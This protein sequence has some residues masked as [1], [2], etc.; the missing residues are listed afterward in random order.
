[1]QPLTL[2]TPSPPPPPPPAPPLGLMRQ[3]I[4]VQSVQTWLPHAQLSRQHAHI[5]HPCP[6]TEPCVRSIAAS[7]RARLLSVTLF[8]ANAPCARTRTLTYTLPRRGAKSLTSHPPPHPQLRR[9]NQVLRELILTFTRTEV[10]KDRARGGTAARTPARARVLFINHMP[11]PR[12]NAQ[13]P[14]YALFLEVARSSPRLRST[15]SRADART[16]PV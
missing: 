8:S 16:K 14:P 6:P 3:P 13:R 12:R 2:K 4:N 9:N 1:M 11:L 5:I 10:I 7:G 15:S